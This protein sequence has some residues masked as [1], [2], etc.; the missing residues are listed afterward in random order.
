MDIKEGG[1]HFERL[2]LYDNFGLC[3]HYITKDDLVGA[4]N[5]ASEKCNQCQEN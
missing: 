4:Y 5:L 3:K 2:Y 1:Y